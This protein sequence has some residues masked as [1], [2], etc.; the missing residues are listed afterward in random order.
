MALARLLGVQYNTAWLLKQ[1]PMQT[2]RE[3]DDSKPLTEPN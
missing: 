1:K 3:R 2:M